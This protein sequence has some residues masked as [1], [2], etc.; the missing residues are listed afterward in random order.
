MCAQ[1]LD[2]PAPS[3]CCA[4]RDTI[5]GGAC[6]GIVQTPDFPLLKTPADQIIKALLIVSSLA[7]G[8]NAGEVATQLSGVDGRLRLQAC[9]TRRTCS[10]C[11]WLL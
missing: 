7:L 6:T 8:Q 5:P 9:R 10:C 11:L 3:I 4:V 1:Q 2:V